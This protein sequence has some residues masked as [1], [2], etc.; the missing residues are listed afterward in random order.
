MKNDFFKLFK[1]S[2]ISLSIAGVVPLLLCAPQGVAGIIVGADRVIDGTTAPDFYHLSNDASLKATGANTYEL[3]LNA[4]SKLFMSGSVVNAQGSEAGI[5]LRDSEATVSSSSITSSSSGLVVTQNVGTGI[6]SKATVNDS[7]ITG[8]L[9]GV[10]VGGLSSVMLN[11][12]AV[13]ATDAK[14]FGLQM[15]GGQATAIDSSITGGNHGVLVLIA[16]GSG[17][18]LS[19]TQ[20]EGLHGSAIR[21]DDFG[22]TPASVEIL[23]SNGS[24]LTGGNGNVLEVGNG[25]TANMTANNS[26][27]KGDVV[28]E[29]GSTANITLENTATLTGNLQNVSSLALNSQGQWIMVGDSVGQ[30]GE[31]S[32]DGGSVKFGKGDEFFTL[33]VASLKGN[34]TFVM[35]ADFTQGKTDFLEVTGQASGSHSLLVGSSGQDPLSDTQLHVVHIGSGD[36]QFSLANG[37]VD[38]G[39]YSYDLVQNGND[40]YLGSTGTISPGT[41]SVLALF[42][43]APT[44]W[45]GELTSLRSRMGEIRLDQGSTGLWMRAY[46]NKFDVSESSGLAYTQNQQGISF[47]A[48][49]PLP[50]GDG[51][52]LAGL[53]GGYSKS[54][55]D[56]EQGTS[57]TVNSYY[58]GAYTTWIDESGYYFDGVLKF[59]RFQNQSS[60]SMSDG[61]RAKGDYD[62]SSVGAS[63][64]VGRH[65]KLANGYFVEPYTQLSGVVIQGKRYELDNGMAADGD[66]TRSLLGK[67][68]VTAGRNFEMSNGNVI[69]P[70]V[71]VAYA[72]EFAKNNEVKVNAEVFNN[73]LSGSRGELGAGVAMSV[74]DRLSLHADFDYSNGDKIEQPWGANVGIRYSW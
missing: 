49:A 70:Y 69:Q 73:D 16:E 50:F 38:L 51:R 4:G 41:R 68:G 21:V 1:V 6:G 14:G 33:S 31:L 54:D 24:T 25:A 10:I 36:A 26:Q 22:A 30:L 62:N 20:V 67:L 66:R 45:Y 9:Q 65:I 35:D 32:M 19:N 5:Y 15:A 37:R 72:R 46:G 28:V 8:G 43:T 57:G 74:S 53:M 71:R 40:W 63:V 52:W 56:L 11:R 23:V 7:A 17:L 47:G 64:E 61:E 55:L 29:A 12:T 34:G 18:T 39:T 2:P 48:D 58:V 59:N 42:N 13:T 3:N 60:V 44:V 27:L